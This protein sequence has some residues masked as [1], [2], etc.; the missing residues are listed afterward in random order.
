MSKRLI[1]LPVA[2]LSAVFACLNAQSFNISYQNPDQLTVCSADTLRITVRNNTAAPL[3]TVFLDLELP[4]GLEYQTGTATGALE[5]DTTDPGKPVLLLPALAPGA[6]ATVQLLLYANCDLIDAINSAQLFTLLLRA[7]SGNFSEQITTAAFQIQT[8]LLVITQIEND[9]VAGEKDDMFI[10]RIHVQNTRLGAVKHL[11]LRDTT[12]TLYSVQTPG[13]ATEQ[14]VN[15]KYA[16]YFDG[17]FFTS[18][19]DG[20]ELLEFGE[21]VV[22]E[23]KITIT[24]CPEN[25]VTERTHLIVDWSCAETAP[26]CQGDSTYAD[27]VVWPWTRGPKIAFTA[28]YPLGWDH[29]AQIPSTGIL[30]FNNIG[31]TASGEHFIT[32]T[33]FPLSEKSGI[34]ASSL[35]LVDH[36]VVTPIIP[37]SVDTITLTDCG[38]TYAKLVTFYIPGIQALDS[39]KILFDVFYCSDPCEPEVPQF[40]VFYFSSQECAAGGGTGFIVQRQVDNLLADV[41][42]NIGECLRDGQTYDFRYV[43]QCERLLADSGYLWLNLDLPQGLSWSTDCASPQLGGKTPVVFTI[44][45]AFTTHPVQRVQMAFELPLN[46]D[47]LSMPFC[48]RSS[49]AG[50]AVF[51]PQTGIDGPDSTGYFIAYQ[52]QPG[53]QCG[54]CG[55]PVHTEAKLS[56]FLDS[57]IDCAWPRCNDFRLRTECDRPDCGGI[58]VSPP[59]SCPSLREHYSALRANFGLTDNDD[60]RMADG[61]GAMD[62][63]KIRRDRLIAGDTLQAVLS[64]KI[65]CGDSIQQFFYQLFTE[66]VRSDYGYANTLDTFEIGPK[67]ANNA[68][69]HLANRDSF[70]VIQATFTVWDSSA[71][72]VYTCAVAPDAGGTDK[73]FGIIAPTNVKPPPPIDELATMSYAFSPSLAAFGAAGCLPP[74]LLLESGDSVA[75]TVNYKLAFNFVPFSAQH[76]P[77]LI[78]FEMGFLANQPEA[79][80]NYRQFD[81]LMFQYSGVWDSL[82]HAQ[83]SIKACEPSVELIPFNYNVR[84][85]R[86]NMFPHEVRPLNNI[87]NYTLSIP[88]GATLLSSEL[89]F[90]NLQENTPVLKNFPLPYTIYNDTLDVDFSPAYADPPDEG[91][92]LR[93]HTVFAPNCTFTQAGKSVQE[94]VLDWNGCI[95]M[96]D[97]DTLRSLNVVGFLANAARDTMTTDELVLDFPTPDEQTVVFIRNKAPVAG[98]NYWIELVNPEGGLSDLAIQSVSPGGPLL[99]PVNGVF[100]LGTLPSLGNWTLNIFAK[101]N[102]CEPQHLQ[103]MYGWDCAP[104]TQAGT[105]ACARKT[106]ELLFRPLNPEIELEIIQTPAEAPLC[107]STDYIVFE[108]SN[109]K[110]GYA[111]RPFA[112]VEL[113]AGFQLVPGSCQMAYP[114]GSA[115]FSIPDPAVLGGNILEWNLA[116]LQPWLATGGLPGVN[117]K[118][119]NA[120]QI[121]FKVLADCGVL[122]NTQLVYGARAEWSC[123]KPTNALRKAGNPLPV[124]GVTP[125]Y[126]TQISLSSGPGG[127]E[128][129]GCNTERG[130]VVNM[131]LSGPAQAG[132]SIF[133]TLP[134]GYT[135]VAGSYQAGINAPA[136]PPQTA[137]NMLRLALPAGVA[138]NSLIQ[139]GFR[140]L[141]GDAPNCNGAVLRVQA[142]Q[143]SAGFCPI[144][145]TD[146]TVYVSTGEAA[147]TFPAADPDVAISAGSVNI[148]PDGLVDLGFSVSNQSPFPVPGPVFS[149]YHDVDG[150]GVLSAADTLLL[151]NF[152]PLPGPLGAG[153]TETIT[154]ENAFPG[155]NICRLLIVLH[156]GENCACEEVVYPLDV[157]TVIYAVQN[158]CTGQSTVVGVPG[159][160]GHTYSWSGAPGLPCDTC[161]QFV[162]MPSGSGLYQL[163]LSDMGGACMLERHFEILVEDRPVLLSPDTAL[164]AGQPVSL[165]TSSATSWAW[166]GPGGLNSTDPV[167]TVQ[168]QQTG[169]YNVVA[170]TAAGCTL[171]ASITI[172]VLPADT[173]DLGTLRTCEGTAV[174]VFGTMTEQPGV[175]RQSLTNAAGCDSVLVL[176]LEVVPH[177]EENR[178]RCP[179]QTLTVFGQPVSVAGT[180]C[181]TFLSSLGCDS[182]HCVVVTDM[183][184]P[185][186][187][188]PDTFYVLQGSSVQLPSPGNFAQYFWAPSDYLNC[189]TCPSPV[190]TPADTI[191]Y[192][193]TVTTDQGCTDT[194]VYRVILSPPCDPSRIRI[195]NA[196]TPNG[197]GDNDVFTVVPYEGTET[198]ERLTIYNRWGQRIYVGTG[199]N[200]SWDGTSDGK[201]AP[202]DVYVWLLEVSCAGEE[203]G[204]RHG[205]VTLLR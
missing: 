28:T 39:L 166:T 35:R 61:A 142:R 155:L 124:E 1:L 196:F 181:Q 34:D 93:T 185:D 95:Q 8:S 130:V 92:F 76:R 192:V 101:N 10:R 103:I 169:V 115:F 105:P 119:E 42:Y 63:S 131:L 62:L 143:Q 54:A 198:I 132:D 140:V 48:L 151:S 65:L 197:D 6:T 64:T 20:D 67:L 163:T 182:M 68:R 17:S 168:P 88:P 136:G 71:N 74:G 199:S 167:L 204:V 107:D 173:L 135:Y 180:Y 16:A 110:L 144:T 57:N 80:Y 158:I 118:P 40:Q 159:E 174:D 109:A 38:V 188:D 157:G 81:T 14:L 69:Q 82:A 24:A 51:V 97:P 13:A 152:I 202:A 149:I 156:A 18:F 77:P 33:T 89:A 145:G 53:D 191:D 133:I 37:A 83:Y 112:T 186:L 25:Q 175:Y 178:E 164:C 96:P 138:P 7:R 58:P 41:Y 91:Y 183:P 49:C 116:A 162:F 55:F 203:K 22:I 23:E 26:P 2:L 123:G 94:V 52:T 195:P 104:H 154:F 161:S 108:I 60:N 78:N 128:P 11:F 129:M 114:T 47:S 85:A 106:L 4:A 36:G 27:L 50:D 187:P 84:L 153:E 44:D 141:S 56:R 205:D 139:F 126:T 46:A 87:S 201:P 147:F 75:L 113:P 43:L 79:V 59:D 29:C 72:A 148:G 3:D 12:I 86:E 177:T 120:L 172:T 66:T 171:S 111:Y 150:N 170:T 21:T 189:T 134:T 122:S 160:A 19:G 190:S 165:Q 137:G 90:L 121:R 32:L 70:Q 5:V 127:N 73:H 98:P 31:Q 117:L 102:T 193:V 100:Q 194:L 184:G 179:E 99:F 176:T 15:G 45:S 30:Q 125:T 146:C 9:S 200:A